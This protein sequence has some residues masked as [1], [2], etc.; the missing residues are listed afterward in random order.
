M[1]LDAQKE[2]RYNYMKKIATMMIAAVMCVMC[3]AGCDKYTSKYEA[4]AFVHSNDPDAA[5]MS[6]SEFEGTMVFTLEGWKGGSK[7]KYSAR[8]EKGSAKISYD[9]GGTKKALC[10]IKS[11]ENTKA[12]LDGIEGE[13]IYIIIESD[14]RC[15]NG[16]MSFEIL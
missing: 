6:F 11:G 1:G 16:R 8:L 2:K 14:Q 12:S 13:T 7:L 5:S 9:C 15:E 10:T 4:V 3:L